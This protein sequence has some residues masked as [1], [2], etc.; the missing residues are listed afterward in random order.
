MVK[1]GVA[2]EHTDHV[3]GRAYEAVEHR[4]VGD[5]RAAPDDRRERNSRDVRVD[6]QRL[7]L[8]GHPI[9]GDPEP[10]QVEPGR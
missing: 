4:R 3:F 6:E 1:M 2:D 10:F 8:V 9:A 5:R 7:A